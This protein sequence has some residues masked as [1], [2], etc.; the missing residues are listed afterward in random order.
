MRSGAGAPPVGVPRGT[1]TRRAPQRYRGIVATPG[2]KRGDRDAPRL[3]RPPSRWTPLRIVLAYAIFGVLWILFSDHVAAGLGDPD[4]RAIQS[5]KGAAYVL[6]TAGLLYLLIDRNRS[7]MAARDEQVRAVL[8]SIP[9]AVFVMNA[10]HQVV[11][12]NAAAFAMLGVKPTAAH[13]LRFE[14]LLTR[15]RVRHPDGRALSADDSAAVRAL[16][17]VPSTHEALLRDTNGREL[18]VSVSAAPVQGPGTIP[19]L[20]VS[21]LRDISDVKR[22]EQTREEFLATAA[23]ELKTP[24]AVVKAYAQL[25]QKRSQGDPGALS[26][27]TR[28]AD[29]LNRIVQQLLEVSRFRLGGDD[30]HRERFDLGQ[31]ADEVT[32]RLQETAGR[33]ILVDRPPC[34]AAVLAD[35]ERIGQVVA[36]LVENALR[37]SP[38]GGEV[39]ATVRQLDGDV[40]LS[41]RDRG[42]GIPSDRQSRIFERY[43]RAHAGTP[44][45]YGGLG[46]GLD[47]SREI[48]ARHG[49]RIWFESEA[50]SGSTFSFSLPLAPE[51]GP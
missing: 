38:T 16:R 43:Y 22:F 14:D 24:L 26:A 10:A 1:L 30:L 33:P 48:V 49:G 19:D 39:H 4:S 8:D 2:E 42:V 45:D 32:R 44:Q 23:H 29:R 20:V 35:R 9:D 18:F 27:I 5:L 36:S 31:L 25:M 15:L 13:P 6:T 34:A 41:V 50:G 28:Q 47:M 46:L 12:V 40:V 11:D 37:F 51:V 3:P 7:R 17:G 21:V